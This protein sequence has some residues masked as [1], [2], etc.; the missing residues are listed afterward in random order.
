MGFL[1]WAW[2][3]SATRQLLKPAPKP[4]P[5]LATVAGV[6]HRLTWANRNAGWRYKCSCGWIDPKVRWTESNAIRAGNRHVRQAMSRPSVAGAPYPVP[7]S[8]SRQGGHIPW[9]GISLNP[10][11]AKQSGSVAPWRRTTDDSGQPHA[12]TDSR[13]AALRRTRE[14]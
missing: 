1:R 2:K 4:K 8:T 10:L 9:G 6:T 11:S 14:C 5:A 13:G 12:V 7:K 3:H